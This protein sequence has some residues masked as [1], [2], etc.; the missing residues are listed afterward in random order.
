[1]QL[2]GPVNALAALFPW[3]YPPFPKIQVAGQT[4][5]PSLTL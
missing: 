4:P 1:M 5:Q 2:S 3:K